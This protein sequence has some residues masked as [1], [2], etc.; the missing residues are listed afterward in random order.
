ML[1]FKLDV[2]KK[3]PCKNITVQQTNSRIISYSKCCTAHKQM[4]SAL[5]ATDQRPCQDSAWTQ[6]RE[7]LTAASDRRRLV[8]VTDKRVPASN[9]RSYSRLSWGQI[10][11]F[12]P[13]H[14]SMHSSNLKT[15]MSFHS[16]L[17]EQLPGS[18]ATLLGWSWNILSHF[19]AH[20]SNT[21][22]VNFYQNS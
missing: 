11:L 17:S 19:V 5:V 1:T 15:T 21:L 18:V 4:P 7:K 16:S 13:G 14:F 10:V 12:L 3:C 22:H 6:Q 8:W 9:P 2:M 20:L